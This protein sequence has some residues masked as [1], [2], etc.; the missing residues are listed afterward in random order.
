ME[1]YNQKLLMIFMFS[2]TLITIAKSDSLSFNYPS[3]TPDLRSI[4]LDGEVSSISGGEL[5][6]TKTN[7][8]T[9]K[10]LPN[11]SGLSAYF[12]PVQLFNNQTDKVA[13][14]TTEFTFSVTTNHTQPHGDGFT[15]F[16]AS[17]DFDFPDNSSGGYLGLFNAETAFNASA[18]QVVAVEF[19]SYANSWDPPFSPNPH[20]GINVN[21]I[22]SVVVARWPMDSEPDGAIGKAVISYGSSSRQL[23]VIVSYPN[24]SSSSPVN[25]TLSYPVD[26]ANALQSEWAYVG[27]SASTG[28]LVE[29]HDI[30]S[31]Y[32]TS[33]V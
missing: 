9:G 5:H 28:D 17:L 16:L 12:G 26:F 7:P 2:L 20:I 1:N 11:R 3:F 31:W 32:F 6:L 4:L 29:S 27:F 15:F 22:G 10:A 24:T 33:S 18:N 30:L 21:T 13:D 14:F 23:S 19:D 25:A 8:Y